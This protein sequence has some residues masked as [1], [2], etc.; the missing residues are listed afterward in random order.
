[1]NSK[2]KAFIKK[3]FPGLSRIIINIKQSVGKVIAFQSFPKFR[4]ASSGISVFYLTDN[5][6]QRP[7]TRKEYAH[8]GRVK[9]VYLAEAFPH[10]FPSANILYA[11]SSV[12]HPLS[13]QIVAKA[14]QKKLKIIVNQNGVAYP[15]CLGLGWENTNQLLKTT[16]DQADYIVYQSRF[17]QISA[18]RFLSPPSVPSEILYNPVDTHHFVPIPFSKKPKNLTLLLGGNQYERYR[19]ELAIRTLKALQNEAPE[20]RL[21]VTGSLWSPI[22]EAHIVVRKLL[23]DLDLTEKVTFTGSYTQNQAPMI[24]TQAHVLLHTKYNDPSPNLISEAMSCGLPVAYLQCG[25]VPEL[26]M[27]AGVGVP[28]EESW[29]QINLPDS[30]EMGKAVLQIMS[31]FEEFSANAR[32]RAIN[33]FSLKSFIEKHRRIFEKVL[34]S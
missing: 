32:E 14:K 34:E 3:R 5:Y 7:P 11:V 22:Q 4:R 28:V 27:D 8:G 26:V 6:P 10:S 25:G 19:L 20:A 12:G 24:F 21:I 23:N 9:M 17:C 13:A 18:E 16:I 15:A 31:H 29:E 1:M 33:Q 30:D 2:V